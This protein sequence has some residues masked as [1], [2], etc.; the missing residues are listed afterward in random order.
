MVQ[1][2]DYTIQGVPNPAQSIAQGYQLGAGIRDD[3][4]QQTALQQQAR[5]AQ[6]QQQAIRGLLMNPRASG[7]DYAAASLLFPQLKDQVKQA[8]EM[9]NTAQQESMARDNGQVFAALQAGKPEIAIQS[10]Q[11]RADAMENAG[12]DPRE[13]QQL[14]TQAQIIEADPNYARASVGMF[15]SGTEAGRKILASAAVA[16]QEQRAQEQA[17]A[18]LAKANAEAGIKQVEAQAAPQATALA[19]ENAAE[20]AETKRANRDIARLNTQIAQAN[21][22]T[23]RGELIQ[24]RDELALKRD[25]AAKAKGEAEQSKLDKI[26]LSLNTVNAIFKHPGLEALGFDQPLMPGFGGV[27]TTTGKMAGFLPGTDRKDLQGLVDTLQAQ[28]FLTGVQSLVGMGAL[29]DAEGKK[30]GSAV[31]SLDLDQSPKAFKNALG[32]VKATLEKAQRNALSSG[33]APTQ[34]GGFVLK[35]PQFGVVTEGDVNRM[36][37]NNP[38][39]TRGQVIQY[40]N[41]TGGK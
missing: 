10:L 32:V 13:I 27:G 30:I 36:M 12:A 22:E 24:K 2:L 11:R 7:E 9:K 14:R 39:S 18:A 6:Q 33:R 40:L 31:A 1:P 4:Q 5:A 21:S 37:A 15:L 41:S 34:G 38:G 19:L 16:G 3:M 25:E 28:Q 26:D 35:H 17:P 29:S 20:D 8:W 23:Q